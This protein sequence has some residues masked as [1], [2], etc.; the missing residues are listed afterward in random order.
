[1]HIDYEIMLGVMAF[2]S[3]Y[4]FP[5]WPLV[6]LGPLQRRHGKLVSMGLAWAFMASIGLA[7]LFA[8]V[9]PRP[10]GIPEPWNT[11]L[12]VSAG[13]VLILIL[14]GRPIW[15]K[16]V[17]QRKADKAENVDELLSLSPREFE[18][19]A[20]DLYAAMGHKARRTGSVGD[21]GV[22]VVVETASGEKWIV[23]C[24]RW[25]GI[26]GESVIRDFFGVLHHEKADRGAVLTTGTFSFQARQWARGKPI[27][28]VEGDELLRLLKRT[29]LPRSES[30]ATKII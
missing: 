16:R 23:Q 7:S 15:R 17:N 27:E 4:L 10:W 26:V 22:D 2:V 13:L 3:G 5:L 30:G 25:R 12:F 29:R 8:P 24:K 20:V 14:V 9:K 28:L 21:H 18:D 19:L 6:I 1:M 11:L